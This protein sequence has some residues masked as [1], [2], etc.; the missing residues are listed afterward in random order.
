MALVT[1]VA[2]VGTDEKYVMEKGLHKVFSPR[3]VNGVAAAVRAMCGM[4][5]FEYEL[6]VAP[7][8]A[9]VRLSH[10]R[11]EGTGG[12]TKRRLTLSWKHNPTR[13]I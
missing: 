4:S 7:F 3:S 6:H 11:R 8:Q 10:R 1:V 5:S 12:S 9:D 2:P 13:K